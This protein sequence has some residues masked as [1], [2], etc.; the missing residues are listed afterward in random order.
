MT[1]DMTDPDKPYAATPAGTLREQFM[2]HN[3]PKSEREWWAST[4]IAMLE[5]TLRSIARN[6]CCSSCREAATVA[7][8]ALGLEVLSAYT[9]ELARL[10]KIEE[11]AILLSD[12]LLGGF[13]VCEGCG[14]QET[15]TDLDYAKE[16]RIALGREPDLARVDETPF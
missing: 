10:R 13:V 9:D 14:Q 1:G 2:S 8:R 3:T 12:S 6:T 15:T 4:H 16:L 7:S 5:A 11:A